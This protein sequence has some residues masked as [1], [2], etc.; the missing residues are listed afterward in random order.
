MATF[1]DRVTIYAQAGNGGNGCAS[2]KREKFKPLG[3]P[4]GANGGH[5]GNVVA[6]VDPQETTLLAFH[7]APHQKAE[8]GTQGAGDMRAGRNGAD[9][10]LK[11]PSGTV[12]RAAGG[13]VLADLVGPGEQY[14]IAR[15]RGRRPRKR[16]SCIA[17]A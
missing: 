9:L 10:V 7:H 3:G 4:D 12:I 2:V 15:G 5:G 13:D 14:V 16:G 11:V 8:S 17:K 6:E 1:V